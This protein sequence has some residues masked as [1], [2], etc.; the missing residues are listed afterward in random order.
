LGN[1]IHIVNKASEK[2]LHYVIDNIGHLSAL[3]QGIDLAVTST[4]KLKS[5][6]IDARTF[7][8]VNDEK[9]IGIL[10]TSN[11]KIGAQDIIQLDDFYILQPYQRKG[12]GGKLYKFALNY[13]RA[14]PL[15]LI[16]DRPSAVLLRFLKRQGTDIKKVRVI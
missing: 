8:L 10:T 11:R 4:G 14:A 1:G 3:T 16:Y 5:E 6:K 15:D 12:F 13:H 9:P 2:V 7:L